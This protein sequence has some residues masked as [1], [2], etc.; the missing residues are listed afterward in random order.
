MAV[1]YQA[2]GPSKTTRLVETQ[3]PVVVILAERG[4][5]HVYVNLLR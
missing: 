1:S 4:A 2:S 5:K 3:S